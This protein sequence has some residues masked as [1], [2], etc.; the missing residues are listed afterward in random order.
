MGVLQEGRMKKKSFDAEVSSVDES[1]THRAGPILVTS[2]EFDFGYPAEKRLHSFDCWGDV[3]SRGTLGWAVR[4][5]IKLG[6]RSTLPIK[7]L[8][9]GTGSL[10]NDR[11]RPLF[12][13]SYSRC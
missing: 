4:L 5:F 9:K 7:L 10:S 6:N 2:R 8:G 11:R 12:T 3:V 1:N 13:P